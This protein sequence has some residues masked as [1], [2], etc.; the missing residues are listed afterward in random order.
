MYTSLMC[1][2]IANGMHLTYTWI[3]RQYIAQPNRCSYNLD[4]EDINDR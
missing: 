4:I 3:I 1:I 2:V